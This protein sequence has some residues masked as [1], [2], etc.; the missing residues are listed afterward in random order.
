LMTIGHN[1]VSEEN[2]DGNNSD[3]AKDENNVP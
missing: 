2:K 3:D 1:N